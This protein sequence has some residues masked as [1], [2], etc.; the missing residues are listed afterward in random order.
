MHALGGGDRGNL[1]WTYN[2]LMINDSLTDRGNTWFTGEI[3]HDTTKLHV[4]FCPL[5]I[6]SAALELD[7]CLQFAGSSQLQTIRVIQWLYRATTI[8]ME[9]YM[10]DPWMVSFTVHFTFQ[11]CLGRPLR[12]VWPTCHEISDKTHLR[13]DIRPVSCPLTHA[14]VCK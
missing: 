13:C 9:H 3:L 11:R 2:M 14:L 5:N 4:L 10:D 6:A 8:F 1:H 7:E 12:Y